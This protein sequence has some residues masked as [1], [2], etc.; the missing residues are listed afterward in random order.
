M[1]ISMLLG[2]IITTGVIQVFVSTRSTNSLNQAISEVQEYGR[3]ITLRLQDEL[4][5]VGRYEQTLGNI[6]NSVD[7]VTE[8][9]FVL[10]QPVAL[11]ADYAVMGALG[12]L[13]GVGNASDELVVN[14][15]AEQ[16]CSGNRFGLAAPMQLHIVNHFFVEDGQLKCQGYSG[17]YL[18]G[19]TGN[20]IPSDEVVL[21]DGVQSMQIEYGLSGDITENDGRVIRYVDG[22]HLSNARLANM[23]VV[24]IRLA[25]LVQSPPIKLQNLANE[26]VTLLSEAP[27]TLDKNHYYQVFNVAVAL[28]NSINYVGS[29]AL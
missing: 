25:L 24:A 26:K 1:M 20:F 29:A 8:S 22:S 19:L 11:A 21:L 10:R 9:S 7:L 5:E 17:R 13:E 18:R 23:Q 12:S 2:L 3:Y 15:L 27:L 16:D 6:D 4:R 28:R 14:L